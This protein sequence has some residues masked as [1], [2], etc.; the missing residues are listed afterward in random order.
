MRVCRGLGA[1]QSSVKLLTGILIDVEEVVIPCSKEPPP[2]AYVDKW[3][4]AQM[5]QTGHRMPQWVTGAHRHAEKRLPDA[6]TTVGESLATHQPLG[7]LK[8]GRDRKARWHV[9]PNQ[10]VE[11]GGIGTFFEVNK[12]WDESIVTLQRCT[13]GMDCQLSAATPICCPRPQPPVSSRP[14]SPDKNRGAA[15]GHGS[16]QCCVGFVAIA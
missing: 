3:V 11:L 7:Q 1:A 4:C 8:S 16:M 6:L 5:L 15:K 12:K 14:T 10:S 9:L 13:E 2:P